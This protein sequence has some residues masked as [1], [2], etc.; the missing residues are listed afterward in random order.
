MQ[1]ATA[2]VT[3]S[4]NHLPGV[5]KAGH[6]FFNCAPNGPNVFSVQRDVPLTTALEASHLLLDSA[7]E[8][9]E[10]AAFH[11]EG[12]DAPDPRILY[13][14]AY[15]IKAAQAASIAAFC[16]ASV[17]SWYRPEISG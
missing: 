9:A 8:I 5:T 13:G 4:T 10:F 2:D 12:G 7:H 14:V 6:S 1:Q 15:L 17:E 3:S 16:A 11:M